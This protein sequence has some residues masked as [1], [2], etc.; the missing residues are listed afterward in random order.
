[1]TTDAAPDPRALIEAYY[2]AGYTDGLPVVPPSDES[3]EAMLAAGGFRGDEVL[4]E[5]AGRNTVVVA[6]KVAINAVMAGCRPEYLP[7]VAAAVKALCHPDFAYHGPASSTGGSAMVLIVNG[8]IARRLGVNA[9][10]NAFGQ[11][12]R[13]NA[14]IGRAVRLTMM[15][16]MNTRPGLLDRATL[17]TPGKYAFCFAEHEEDHPWEPLHVVRGLQPDDSAVTLYAS[18]SLC[19]V[20]NQLAAEPE[21]LLLCLADALC[22]LGSPNVKGFNESLVVLAGEHTEVLRAAKWTRRQVQEFL[23]AH[24]RRRLADFKRAARLPGPVQPAD[25]TTWRHVFERPEDILIACAGG[26][27]GSW[28]ACL[29]GWGNKWTRAVTVRVEIP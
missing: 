24:A 21:P 12:H 18:N 13:P 25:E 20:Y 23:V 14:T 19:Q 22:N 2:E 15:N 4:G 29:P 5:I 16:V 17:G 11:G 6:D 3:I 26:R 9:G 1:V 10:N 27:A 8:P 28:S 7:V